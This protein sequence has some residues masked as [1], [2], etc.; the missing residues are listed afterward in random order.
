MDS[1]HFTGLKISSTTDTPIIWRLQ[2]LLLPRKDIPDSSE[3][4]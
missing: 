4:I 2:L 1:P 3:S